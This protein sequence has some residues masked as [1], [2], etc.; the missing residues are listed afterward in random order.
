VAGYKTYIDGSFGVNLDSGA[1]GTMSNAAIG[2]VFSDGT[3]VYL[4][5]IA[6]YTVELS[7]DNISNLHTEIMAL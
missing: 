6:F 2:Q 1:T 5:A 7:A 4:K 3:T